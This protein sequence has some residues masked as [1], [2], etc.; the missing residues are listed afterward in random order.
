MF[1]SHDQLAKF[2]LPEHQQEIIDAVQATFEAQAPG[3]AVVRDTK[4]VRVDDELWV[5]LLIR[6]DIGVVDLYKLVLHCELILDAEAKPASE[7]GRIYGEA[8]G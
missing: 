6:Y 2:R 1:P 7:F 8:M 4:H 5:D 3:E